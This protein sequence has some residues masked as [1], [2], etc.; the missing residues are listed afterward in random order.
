MTY[1]PD[2]NISGSPIYENLVSTSG[3]PYQPPAYQLPALFQPPDAS[4]TYSTEYGAEYGA[5]QG[6]PTYGSPAMLSQFLNQIFGDGQSWVAVVVFGGPM[7]DQLRQ[8]QQFP[9][10]PFAQYQQSP[11]PALPQPFWPG[12]GGGYADASGFGGAPNGMGAEQAAM[13]QAFQAYQQMMMYQW[14]AQQQAMQQQAVQQQVMQQQAMMPGQQPLALTAG[15]AIHGADLSMSMPA[16]DPSDQAA[17]SYGGMVT[18]DWAGWLGQ[19]SQNVRPQPMAQDVLDDDQEARYEPSYE[20][21][22]GRLSSR[23][24]AA[25]RELRGR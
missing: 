1:T 25:M 12:A 16:P 11:E 2:L 24:G 15:P 22:G 3:D 4:G 23:L 10:Q 21:R 13:A 19:T 6:A 18:E 14:A 8:F 7:A 20:R 9:Q 17:V 5:E